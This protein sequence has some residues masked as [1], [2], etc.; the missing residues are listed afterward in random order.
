MKLSTRQHP[1]GTWYGTLDGVDVT[2][3]CKVEQAAI[4]MAQARAEWYVLE[5]AIEEFFTNVFDD[6]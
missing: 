5:A 4:D 6:S 3:P 1:D 2:P